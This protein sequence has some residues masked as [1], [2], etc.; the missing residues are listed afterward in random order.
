MHY[1]KIDRNT[2]AGRIYRYLSAM[3]GNW[4]D[5]WTLTAVTRT[6]AVSTRVSVVRK[7]LELRGGPEH[8]ESRQMEGKWFYR[9]V[10]IAETPCVLSKTGV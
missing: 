7:Q 9:I 10:K 8:V 5:S 1:G 6:A 4:C 2:A 3:R